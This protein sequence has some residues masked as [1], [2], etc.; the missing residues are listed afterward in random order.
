MISKKLTANHTQR[1]L[2]SSTLLVL[3]YTILI[4][5]LPTN[6]NT[7]LTYHLSSINY[8]IIAFV[9][10]L[11]AMLSWFAAFIGYVELHEYAHSIRKTQEGEHFNRLAAGCT[12]LAWSLPVPI[13]I[14]LLLNAASSKWTNLQGAAIIISNYLNLL[15][16][17]IAFSIIGTASRGLL[18]DAKLKFS[19]AS[20]RIIVFLFLGAGVLYCYL[21]F[22]TF[23]STS[24]ASTDNPY[25]L[26]IWLLVL[27]V[28]IPYLYAWFIGILAAYEISLFSKH[29][30]GV[31]YRQ[32][33]RL[34][35]GGLIAVIV[36]SIALQYIN[37]V[38]P[39]VSYLIV[40]YRLGLTALFRVIG[41]GGFVLLTLG[42]LRLKKIEEV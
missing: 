38:Q 17:L 34:L 28:T 11:P 12:W 26:P 39:R 7:I 15:L 22:R 37:S 25:F 29:L 5:L 6:Q 36:S 40:D 8:R 32:A 31:L 9:I 21:T 14:S 27:T 33:L 20:A 10:A 24:L 13:I 1:A 41:G 16:P 4:F 23:D 2:Q 19:L 18:D 42:A 30:S 35:V 3:I